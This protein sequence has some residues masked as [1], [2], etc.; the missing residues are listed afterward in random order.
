[1][2]KMYV[3]VAVV[4]LMGISYA[5]G[6]G[7]EANEL[8]HNHNHSHAEGHVHGEEDDEDD[9]GHGDEIVLHPEDA[10]KFGVVVDTILPDDFNEVIEVAGRIINTANEQA[11]IAAPASGTVKFVAGMERGMNVSAGQAIA[12]ISS[13]GVSGGNVDA[14]SQARLEAAKRELERL[15][16]LFA[17][18]IV[19]KR[20]YNAAKLA[21]EEA[22]AAYSPAAASGRATAPISGILTELAVDAG[23]YVESGAPIGIVSKNTTVTLQAYLPEQKAALVSHINDATIRTSGSE[24]WLNV[25]ELN[26]KLSGGTPGGENMP[27][28]IGVYFTLPNDGTLLPGMFADVRLIGRVRS[29]VL[30]VPAEAISEQQGEYFVYRRVDDHGYEKIPVTLG[31]S[32]GRRVEIKSGI[33]PGQPIVV[34]GTAFVKLAESSGNVPE[35]HSHNH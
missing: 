29:G 10:E 9:H 26:G 15:T 19:T 3:S 20:D 6:N 21:Y 34:S 13:Q 32:D 30:S 11:T 17:D 2:K 33:E 24:N 5:C 22:K 23:D 18:G 25:S 28:Y 16:P 14:A 7:R 35:G 8:A 1:M 31:Q 12:Y 27:G 4:A